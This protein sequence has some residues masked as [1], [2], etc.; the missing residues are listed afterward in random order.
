MGIGQLLGNCQRLLDSLWVFLKGFG[1]PQGN[2]QIT[3]TRSGGISLWLG[4]M[5]NLGKIAKHLSAK[6]WRFL[7]IFLEAAG[8]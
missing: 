2:A 3:W 6:T 7:S 5:N 4:V 1:K 8:I